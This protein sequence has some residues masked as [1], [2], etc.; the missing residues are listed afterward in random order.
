MLQAKPVSLEVTKATSL[1]KVLNQIKESSGVKIFFSS[2]VT[3][4]I[5]CKELSLNNVPVNVALDEVLK[6]TGLIYQE[7]E[8][9]LVIKQA[10]QGQSAQE[11]KSYTI[12]GKIIDTDGFPLP[13]VAILIKGTKTGFVTD[14]DGNFFFTIKHP[15]W[16]VLQ[17][18]MMGM[19][20]IELTYKGETNLD[21]TMEEDAAFIKEAVVTGIFERDI[22]S[23]TGASVTIK[24]DELKAF[25]NRNIIQTLR[26]ID[27]SFNIVESNTFGSNPNRL[28]EIQ[29][30]GNSNLPNVNELQD[31]TRMALNTPL[32]IL[33]GFQ[34]SLQNL[35]DINENEV[36]SITLLKDASATA[37]YGSRG[38]NGVIVITTKAPTMGK[39]RVTYRGDFNV[40]VPD[41]T[42]YDRLGPREK[43]EIENM[44]GIYDDASAF[45]RIAK[46]R[47]YN[48]IMAEIN[49]GVNTDWMSKP[50]RA[51]VGQKHNLRLEG[52]DRKFRYLASAQVNQINGVMKES[53]RNVFNGNIKLSYTYNNVKFT[54]NLMLGI[55]NNSESP[56]GTFA[57]YTKLNAYWRPYDKDGNLLKVLGDYGDNDHLYIHSLG[58]PANPLYNATVGAYNTG[59]NTEIVNNTSVEWTLFNDL[60]VRGRLGL[61]KRS[62]QSHN[63]KPADH[64]DFANYSPDDFMRRGSYNLGIS[65]GFSYD[66]SL[67][68]SYSKI[69]E[70]N[71]HIFAGLDANFLE[72][73]LTAYGIKAEGFVNPNFDFLSMALSYAKDGK[74]TGSESFNRT[75]GFTANFNYTYDNRYNFDLSGR[76][77]GSSQFG[78][79]NRFTPF[80]SA[81][82]GWIISNESFFENKEVVNRLK[83]RYS[84][85]TTGHQSFSAY[86]AFQTYRYVTDDSYYSWLGAQMMALG[87]PNLTWQMKMNYNIGF[88]ASFLQDR[89]NLVADFYKERVND[90]VSSV[91]IPLANGFSSYIANIGKVENRGFEL[92]ATAFIFKNHNDMTWSIT[93]SAIHNK[94]EIVE[95][96]QAL[97]DAQKPLE[98]AA[99]SNPNILYKEGYSTNTIWVVPSLGIDPST[100]KEIYLDRFGNPTHIWSALDLQA[101]GIDEPKLQGNI[102]SI[103]RYKN[104]SL[105]LSFGYRLGGQLYNQTL[106][107]N[108]ENA[109]FKYNLDKRVYTGRWQK[110]GDHAA[111]KS[112]FVAEPTYKT[113]RFV[114]DE[115]TFNFQNAS[116]RYDL[117]GNVAKK[118]LGAELISF[119]ANMSDL[120][121]LSTVKRER[122]LSYPFSRQVSFS[123]GITF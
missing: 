73:Q 44:V 75:A 65:N 110:P 42:S 10:P 102:N 24:S 121:Y 21:L 3:K 56:Y 2:D 76:T 48:K 59:E 100:G 86:Q 98:Q 55:G 79:E 83:L 74:P 80:W 122:G 89:F 16:P 69:F 54:N 64:T 57:D 36:E 46:Q 107:D 104:L 5:E 63:F 53:Y 29:I 28:P 12:Q 31:E 17:F 66:A 88:E 119:S 61:T 112:L 77:D 115:R 58:L 15:T 11:Q 106:I 93:A 120:F 39:L 51:G 81:G 78:A 50:L 117:T 6:G 70:G 33:D 35:L 103:F 47:Y 14:V 99:N 101:M 82:L 40:E 43:L 41:L 8:G 19:K 92:K 34:S 90:L 68:L 23:F 52:G 1:H 26:N 71:H 13:G 37:I 62:G 97:K 85:G 96:S 95:V 60:V 109:N 30:R 25:G 118:F 84:M 22:N 45:K 94:N 108:V 38:A 116:L 113:S 18:R 72:T 105:N 91:N 67:N 27:P 111:Y 9:A 20:P 114:Q 7:V 123:V 49:S 87:N 32:I 4:G